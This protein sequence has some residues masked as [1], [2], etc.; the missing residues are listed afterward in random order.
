MLST[1]RA[2]F[3]WCELVT[4]EAGHKDLQICSMLYSFVCS[5]FAQQK[6]VLISIGWLKLLAVATWLHRMHNN[7][8]LAVRPTASILDGRAGEENEGK[9]K[10][11]IISVGQAYIKDDGEAS[12]ES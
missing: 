5:I 11:E 6:R 1:A 9:E 10:E 12:K 3:I 7:K 2:L 4:N 8:L